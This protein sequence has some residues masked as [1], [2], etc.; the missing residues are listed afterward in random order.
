MD[1]FD[2]SD[3]DVRFAPEEALESDTEW[4]ELDYV[5]AYRKSNNSDELLSAVT[6]RIVNRNAPGTLGFLWKK[7]PFMRPQGFQAI[8]EVKTDYLDAHSTA[9][10]FLECFL[11]PELWN[12]RET[13]RYVEQRLVPPSLHMKT[14][15]N[16][17]GM[18][19]VNLSDQLALSYS[20][21]RKSNK[22]YQNVFYRL[23]DMAVV[24]AFVV[25][26][27]LGGTF[28]QLEFQL[29]LI[30]DLH[31]PPAYGRKGSLQTHQAIAPSPPCHQNVKCQQQQQ[32]QVPQCHELV[33][34]PGCKYHW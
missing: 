20:T 4:E 1:D 30:A 23:I 10:E 13:N 32:K 27:V 19:G 28:N 18:K 26:R 7:R 33:F 22:W 3:D 24:N 12:T 31:E 17:V 14:W 16:T 5:S 29:E 21:A 2:N 11:M 25:Q 15:E 9:Q 6:C 8:P 34:N